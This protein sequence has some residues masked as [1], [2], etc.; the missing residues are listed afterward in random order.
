MYGIVYIDHNCLLVSYSVPID[1]G[2][3]LVLVY[4]VHIDILMV[5]LFVCC[6][7][8]VLYLLLSIIAHNMYWHPLVL[9]IDIVIKFI[10]KGIAQM[11][12]YVH[13]YCPLLLI[14][15]VTMV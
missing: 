13:W 15:G 10:G 11:L 5:L 4:W 12:L 1:I 6:V 14:I 7:W 8:M 2:Y 3:I 9:Y